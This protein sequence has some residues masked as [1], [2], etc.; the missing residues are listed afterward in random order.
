MNMKETGEFLAA[1]RK[2]LG[3]TQQE[4]ADQLNISNKTVSKWEQGGGYPDLTILPVL[5][6]LYHVTVDEILAGQRSSRQT[7]PDR[8]RGTALRRHL[9]NRIGLHFDLCM[10]AVLVSALLAGLFAYTFWCTLFN[11]LAGGFLIAGLLIANYEL[12]SAEGALEKEEH[13]K[14]FR[15]IGQKTFFAVGLILWS[16]LFTPFIVYELN[17]IAVLRSHIWAALC[18]AGMAA[19][20]VWG[21][22]H[23]GVFFDKVSGIFC[24]AG[25]I[26]LNATAPITGY[27]KE[28]IWSYLSLNEYRDSSL[29]AHRIILLFHFIGVLLIAAGVVRQLVKDRR[30]SEK[31]E[32][33]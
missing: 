16:S 1:L 10:I 31:A 27:F 13:E 8:Q 19:L 4:V 23:W 21:Q 29:L 5:A 6:E 22:K 33:S 11:I 26:V 32:N 12:R 18:T 15:S 14:V 28:T 2:S 7:E 25:L 17:D 30:R 3:Y 20:W 9:L 24:I